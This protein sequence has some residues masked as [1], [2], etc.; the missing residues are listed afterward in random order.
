MLL[1]LVDSFLSH[2]VEQLVT[3]NDV[4]DSSDLVGS[5]GNITVQHW[6]NDSTRKGA[7]TYMQDT[8][9]AWDN[10]SQE[11]RNAIQSAVV[12]NGDGRVVYI[13]P[14]KENPPSPY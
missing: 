4:F 13:G 2:P 3:G 7:P 5:D 11:T 6:G 1:D 8:Q 12:I 14:T 9:V 10:A